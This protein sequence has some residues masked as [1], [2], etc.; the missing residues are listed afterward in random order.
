MARTATLKFIRKEGAFTNGELYAG[1]PGIDVTNAVLYFSIDGVTVTAVGSGGGDVT[2][3]GT[4]V[5]GQ[6]GVWTGSG[7]IEGDSALTFDT[8][9]DT[10]TVAASGKF[11]FGAVTILSDS[12]GTTTL[13]NIDAI[14]S[15]TEST[16]EAAI[17]SLPNLSITESQISNLGA[18]VTLNADTD[19]SGNSWVLDEDNM[20]SNSATKVPTQQS[21]KAYVDASVVGLLDFKDGYDA[22]TNTPDLDAAPSGIMK[23][24]MYVVT[25]AG[26]FFAQAVEIGDSL[27]AKQN[28]PTLLSH[29]T[30]IQGNI[31]SYALKTDNLSVFA[32]TTS[33]QL[34]GVISDETGSGSLVFGTSP[35]IAT[36]TLTLKQSTNPTPT[37]EGAIEWDTDND[38]IVIGNGASQKIFSSDADITITESQISDLGT[39]IALV[40]DDLGA[41]ASTTSAELAGVIS[42][43]TGSGLLVFND[44]PLFV[45]PRVSDTSA[46]H[47]YIFAVSELA[48]DRIVTLPLL[49]SNDTFVFLNHT[50]TLTNKTLGAGCVIDGGTI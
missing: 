26:N 15:T 9:T 39:S 8:S 50:S 19:V 20:S 18:A 44:S 36:P 40:S 46:D 47:K 7:T 14:D 25:V 22:D 48:A 38:R 6:L 2:K 21:V 4:P 29:W 27:I 31:T 13:Q 28:D 32:A 45:T 23:G 49:T 35:T 30:I 16:L 42:D 24:D 43:E 33:A 17:D 12:S 11:A 37:A 34:A 41:F 10:L 3:V 5:D 1:E